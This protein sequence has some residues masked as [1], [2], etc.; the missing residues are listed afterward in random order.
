M[1]VILEIL[2]YYVCGGDNMKSTIELFWNA[3][4]KD[5]KKG[6]T[7]DQERKRYICLICGKTYCEGHIYTFKEELLDAPT[8]MAIHVEES[9]NGMV[10]FLLS[11]DKKYTGLS[12]IQIS[13]LNEF[14]VGKDDS[15]ISKR[16][17]LSKSNVRNHRF[18]LKEKAKQAKVFLTIYE[19]IEERSD[20]SQK[21]I[22]F[23]YTANQVDERYAITESER[24]K[25]I[26]KLFDE[27]GN[28]I[29]FPSKEKEK[30]IVLLKIVN[31]FK[32]DSTYNEKEL[33]MKLKEIYPDFP[34]L[35]RYL[36]EYGLM[37]R[38]SDGSLY[39]VKINK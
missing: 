17:K 5:L 27:N 36:I 16:L 21:M 6:Y 8:R 13:I 38:K 3:T 32:T 19:M 37:D 23:H 12:D 28:L 7:F 25:C 30:L 4:F 1:F 35:R 26:A 9:H 33:N 31:E 39:W 11:M 2:W 10:D 34:L 22:D 15:Q 29:R 18:R 20:S 14:N 24:N